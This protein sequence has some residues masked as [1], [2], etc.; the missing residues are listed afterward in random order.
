MTNSQQLKFWP[1]SY[2]VLIERVLK[3]LKKWVIWF[4]Q[5]HYVIDISIPSIEPRHIISSWNEIKAIKSWDAFNWGAFDRALSTGALLCAALLSGTLDFTVL[6]NRQF[7]KVRQGPARRWN[8]ELLLPVNWSKYKLE[9][10]T[11]ISFQEKSEINLNLST[12]KKPKNEK[13]Y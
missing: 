1:L 7:W 10:F 8:F 6:V 3:W 11:K 2:P 4:K 9:P 5:F 12:G 13:S